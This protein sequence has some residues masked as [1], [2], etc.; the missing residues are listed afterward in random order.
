VLVAAVDA[1]RLI[2]QLQPTARRRRLSLD[3]M[4]IP[5]ASDQSPHLSLT[6]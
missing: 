5:E 1:E 4:R 6:R 2:G 3:A